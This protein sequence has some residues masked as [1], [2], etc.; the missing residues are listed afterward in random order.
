LVYAG[1]FTEEFTGGGGQCS[2]SYRLDSRVFALDTAEHGT[3]V[4]LLTRLTLRPPRAAGGPAPPGPASGPPE[5]AHP[6]GPGRLG[7]R[8]GT[9]PAVPPQGPATAEGGAFVEVPQARLGASQSWT[10][11][12]DGRPPHTWHVAGTEAVGG[13][14]C[15]KVIGVQQS[16]D[17]DRPRAD[18]TA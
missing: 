9:T 12:E 13:T 6:D 14:M 5:P 15:L 18:S 16:A 4:A 3:D 2:R 10:T 8:P 17:W 7:G 1:S 11:A